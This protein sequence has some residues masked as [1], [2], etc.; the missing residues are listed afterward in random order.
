MD[1]SI[2][3]ETATPATHDNNWE[4]R[5]ELLQAMHEIATI[6]AYDDSAIVS[7]REISFANGPLRT[8][9]IASEIDLVTIDG[10]RISE[11]I[12]IRTPLP[13]VIAEMTAEQIAMANTMATT[14]AIVIDPDDG[15]TTLVSSLPVFE[16]DTEALEDL[17]TKMVA[18]GA[19]VQLAGPI[20]GTDYLGESINVDER[21]MDYPAWGSAS[22]W[23]KS[24]FAYANNMLRRAGFCANA[25]ESGLTVEFPWDEGASSAM[26][27]DCTSLMR[28]QSDMPHPVA[29]RGLFFRLDLP[30]TLERRQLAECANYLNVLETT[31]TNLPPI[32]GA[33]CSQLDNGTLSFIGFWPNCMYK[34][35]TVAN[36]ASWCR[37]RSRIARQA[38]GN[39]RLAGE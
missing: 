36:I 16:V 6:A 28:F 4:P 35:G 24:E 32:F 26:L 31:G 21:D 29:G 34:A 33:W 13:A 11:R 38:I 14:G 1:H 5:P 9:I 7:D 17:Y 37:V 12:D 10:F 22:P 27:G 20:A 2:H 15:S 18:V 30:L 3:N 19:L 23:G 39:L 8:S 25:S